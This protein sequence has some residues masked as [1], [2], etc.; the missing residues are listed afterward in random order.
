MDQRVALTP[1]ASN[2]RNSFGEDVVTMGDPIGAWAKA[3]AVDGSDEMRAE[4]FMSHLTMRFWIRYRA[5][6]TSSYQ[7]TWRGTT[8]NVAEVKPIGRKV[9]LELACSEAK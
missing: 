3:E 7:V 6:V 5:A 1:P 8:Y 4:T 9:W 2:A